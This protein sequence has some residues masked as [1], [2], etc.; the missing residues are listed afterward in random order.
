MQ[1]KGAIRFLAIALAIISIYYLSFTWVTTS[2]YK[3]AEEYAK[4]Y[5][6]NHPDEE[7]EL[8]DLEY[9]YLDSLSGEVVYN[10]GIREYTLRECQER[11]INLGLD[12]KGGMNVVLEISVEDII[13]ALAN[14]STDTT[15]RQ[16]LSLAKDYRLE[17]REDFI[18]LFGRAF[19]EI[20]PDARLAAIFNTIELKDKVDFNSTNQ[21]VL[22]VIRAEAQDAIDNSF[23]ILRSR[24][25]RFGVVQPNIQRLEAA[26]RVMVELP[27]VKDQE[28]V[29]DLLQGTAN[30]E[31]WE[32]YNNTQVYPF[33]LQAN[34]KIYELE[35]ARKEM[36]PEETVEETATVEQT[37]EEA[38]VQKDGEED[39]SLLD[40]IE[41]ETT[42]EDSAALTDAQISER[43]PLFSILRPSINPRTNQ[44]MEGSVVG[45][46]HYND[47]AKVNEYLN[48]KQ[49]RSIF[50]RDI[51][52]K[53]NVKA[54]KYDETE[55]FYEL[56]AL[57]I[58][59][60]DGKPPLDGDVITDA[61]SEFDQNTGSAEVS[62][63]MNADGA[64]VWARL[65]KNNVGNFIAIV[66]DD[67]VYSA[68]RVNQEI[69][70]GRSSISGDF[71]VE[72]AKDLANILKSG[73]LPA[74]AR[75][76]QEEVVGPSLGQEAINA[77][78]KSFLI[79]FIVVMIY[80]VFYFSRKAGLVADIA[81]L[82]NMFFILGVLASLG[83]VLTLPGI[84]GI[85]LTIGM[86]VDANVLIYDRIREELAAGKGVKLAVKDGYKNA[87]SAIIDANVTTL[88]TAII[89]YTFGTG[90]IKGFATTLLIGI[91][92]SLFTAIFLTRLIFEW[93]L[94]RNK[95]ITYSTKLT[96]NVLKNPTFKFLEKR[97]LAYVVS[98]ILIFISLGSLFTKGL[99]Q[100]VDFTG[101]RTYVVRFEE[102]VNTIEV[103]NSLEEQYG[104]APE[105]KVFGEENQVKIT[106]KYRIE[107]DD[108][109]VDK[110]VE[111]KLFEGLKPFIQ[112]TD[113]TFDDFNSDYKMSSHKVGA[114]IATDIIYKS[115]VVIVLALI[116]MFVYIFIRFKNW[117]YGLGAIT[118]LIHDVLIIL[119]IFSLAAGVLPFSLEI[120]QAFIAAILTVVGYS[121]N[122]TVVVFDR[123]REYTTLYPKRDRHTII[124][125]ALNGTL[126]R[127][128][129]TSLTTFVV[130]LT[131]FLL[132]GEVIRGFVFALLVGVVVGTY[133]SLFIASP[134]V[135]DTVHKD[136]HKKK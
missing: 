110:E 92:T 105:V 130:L 133:S 44:P 42:Q 39:L 53:W 101:G 17:S 8:N 131:I 18:T 120:D 32:T 127:T 91:I 111:A 22:D 27:G 118:A 26:G 134:V 112:K 125:S 96:E 37:T 129:N 52:F 126:S 40:Q 65:T 64:K 41:S 2:I 35:Q 123:I 107:E 60:R 89:L 113:I 63:T 57:K 13:K 79:A 104:S 70:G 55:S 84:A 98:A 6:A 100:G 66:L 20:D 36:E 10:L 124:N 114:T 135:Y 59:G 121:V 97:K 75:I 74:P 25:D 117:Q 68:P 87:Y 15:F 21:E 108:V 3:D 80:M 38:A 67:Y 51:S 4:E 93:Y 43:Y 94:K 58:T 31:F 88:L 49:V 95:E 103:A 56:H 33:L 29:R 116:M 73:K 62:M 54:Y 61:R 11:E 19:N 48:M 23:N 85:V 90:P 109:D 83:A 119:G 82:V 16:A 102:P 72:E 81:L 1:I 132:G 47:T 14:N 7:V 115:L 28:R 45:M 5:A 99:N 76:I 12:L 106:T 50:P 69:T 77:G 71:T 9:Q 46:A 86:S 78:M 24:I 30:L 34:E 128:F 136:A 122:D